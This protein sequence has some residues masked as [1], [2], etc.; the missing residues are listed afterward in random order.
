MTRDAELLAE[1]AVLVNEADDALSAL[2]G[3]ARAIRRDCG[4]AVAHVLLPDAS[5]AFVTSDLWDADHR[6]LEFF[7]AVLA[8][9]ADERFVPPRGLP[10]EV[11][12]SHLA[13][14]WPDLTGAPE[15]P[16]RSAIGAGAGWAFPVVLGVEVVAVLEL[17]H[18]VPRA[19]D[20]RLLQL[21]PSLGAQLARAVQRERVLDEL[22]ADRRRLEELVA[23]QER[24]IARLSA[25]SP[26]VVAPGAG[27]RSRPGDGAASSVNGAAGGAASSRVLLVDDNDINRRLAAAMLARLGVPCDV[28]ADAAQAHAAMRGVAY[29]LV[30]MDVQMPGMDGREAAGVWRRTGSGATP[31]DVPIVALTAHVGDHERE[32]C[33]RAGMDGYLSKP[34]GLDGLAETVTRWLG[35]GQSATGSR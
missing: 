32:D 21:A 11:A 12:A 4:F 22:A 8:A 26:A 14:W 20:E 33:V 18:P 24:E 30:L 7:D 15:D 28:A 9:T 27:Q 35:A 6:L 23:Q 13:A 34:F 31:T 16:R 1:V 29:G 2:S 10:G 25:S 19:A 5:G 17:L 3:A